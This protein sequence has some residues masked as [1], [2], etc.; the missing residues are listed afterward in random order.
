MTDGQTS[1]ETREML[2]RR[3]QIVEFEHLLGQVPGAWHGDSDRAPLEHFFSNGI[4]CR[5]ILLPEGLL[6]TGK[7]HKFEHPYV[8]LSGRIMVFTEGEGA[9]EIKGPCFGIS[10]AGTKRVVLALEDTVWITFHR[11]DVTDLTAVEEEIIAPDFQSL[12]AAERK[13]LQCH[14]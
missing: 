2:E 6:A 12:D 13:E 11:T 4:Y 1:L 7:I 8:V 5:K 9:V 3:S 14:S 10:P